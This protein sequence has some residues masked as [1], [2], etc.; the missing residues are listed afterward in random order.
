NPQ[1][2]IFAAIAGTPVRFRMLHPDGLGGFPDDVWTI[3]GHTWQEEPYVSLFTPGGLVVPSGR[4][5]NN[6]FSQWMGSRDGFG[7]GNHFDILIDSAGG[8]NKVFG[9]YLYKSFPSGEATTGVWGIFRVCNPASNILCVA[10][11]RTTATMQALRAMR[12]ARLAAAPA[13]PTE[14]ATDPGERFNLRR[15]TR[16]LKQQ[17]QQRRSQSP[18]P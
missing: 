11:A 1:T 10:P 16:R 17:Q 15:Q 6:P 12:A 7:P 3:H 18:R 2:P 4:L 9:D 13:S 5:G 14:T 8:I